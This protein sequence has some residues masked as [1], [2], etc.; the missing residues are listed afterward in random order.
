MALKNIF[1]QDETDTIINRINA[2]SPNTSAKWGKMNAAQMLAHCSVTYELVYE[3]KHPQPNFLMQAMLKLFL[4]KIVT[5]EIPYKKNIQTGPAFLMKGEKDFEV[6]KQRLINYILQTQQLGEAHFD[7]KNSHSFG[8]LNIEEWN[9]MFY[10][11]LH[12]HLS[13]FGV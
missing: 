10:K 1:K 2:L 4:K 5:S 7:K 3:K 12:H 13:Q 8:V 9:N 11:H 6:E